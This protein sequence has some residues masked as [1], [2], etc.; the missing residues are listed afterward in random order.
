VFGRWDTGP[1]RW[2]A[3]LVATVWRR[4]RA[5]FWGG[6]GA[7]RLSRSP[8]EPQHQVQGGLGRYP[9]RLQRTAFPQQLARKDE[10][11]LISWHS[12]LLFRNLPQTGE[13]VCGANLNCDRAA[14]EGLDEYLDG[15]GRVPGRPSFLF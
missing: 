10:P 5:P 3:V 14:L 13:M 7:V 12:G 1:R 2:S 4:G 11:L 8:S 6:G 15:C 9:L